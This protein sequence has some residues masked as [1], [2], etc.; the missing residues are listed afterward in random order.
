M[1]L[2]GRS[3]RSALQQTFSMW[4][5][6]AGIGRKM[7]S[8]WYARELVEKNF[9]VSCRVRICDSATAILTDQE[10]QMYQAGQWQPLGREWATNI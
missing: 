8:I 5:A 6:E 2:K 10:E 3:S 1:A 4:F 9:Q 7:V